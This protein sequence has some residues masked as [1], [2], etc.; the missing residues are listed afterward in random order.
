MAAKPDNLKRLAR[1]ARNFNRTRLYRAEDHLLLVEGH[2]VEEY[3]RFFHR[4]LQAALWT[5]DRLPAGLLGGLFALFTG[6][7][8]ALFPGGEEWQI[9][10]G[11]FLAIPAVLILLRLL[12]VLAC[13]G[14]CKFYLCTAAQQTLIPGVSTRRHARKIIR[15]LERH[16]P[17]AA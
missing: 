12:Y 14:Y 8:V 1:G 3:R 7:A 15:E 2:Y 17:G 4:D 16:V 6:G 5:P 13:G 10:I 11:V 9:G